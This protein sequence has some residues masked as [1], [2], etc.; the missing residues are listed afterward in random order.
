MFNKGL[1]WPSD[2]AF[3]ATVYI[4]VFKDTKRHNS[5]QKILTTLSFPWSVVAFKIFQ[6]HQLSLDQGDTPSRISKNQDIG[7]REGECVY[8]RFFKKKCWK[9]SEWTLIV[10]L[11]FFLILMA[12]WNIKQTIMKAYNIQSCQWM[13]DCFCQPTEHH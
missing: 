12:A 7:F 1:F 4:W 8:V 5:I 6:G 10:I 2:L 9:F 13:C 11:Q 3:S